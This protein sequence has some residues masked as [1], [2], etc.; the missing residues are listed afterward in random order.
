MLN[1]MNKYVLCIFYKCVKQ[2]DV[3][4]QVKNKSYNMRFCVKIRT[5]WYLN[6]FLFRCKHNNQ[7]K[8]YSH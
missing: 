4:S 5:I 3:H 2:I 8:H 7:L 6:K 1:Y